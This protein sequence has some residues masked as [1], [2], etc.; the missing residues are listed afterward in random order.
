MILKRANKEWAREDVMRR[1]ELKGNE[2]DTESK[3]NE[4]KSK[5]PCCSSG[6]EMEE[7]K[8]GNNPKIK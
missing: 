5:L 4:Y 1:H 8:K 7:K 2:K 6:G 3:G